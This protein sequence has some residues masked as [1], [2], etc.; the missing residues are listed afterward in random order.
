MSDFAQC[1]N[2]LTLVNKGIENVNSKLP[3]EKGP[4]G[5]LLHWFT[6]HQINKWIIFFLLVYVVLLVK[7]ITFKQLENSILFGAYSILVSIYILSRFLLAYFYDPTPIPNANYT[8]TVTF[9]TPAK[10]EEENISATLRAMMN[11][12]YPKSRFEIIAIND[13]STDAT[14]KEMKKVEKEAIASGVRLSVVNW[15][16]NRGKRHGMAEGILRSKSQIIV[17]VD[18]DSFVQPSTLRALVKYFQDRKVAAVAGHADVYN[19]DQNLLTKMQAVRY[20]VAFRAYKSAEALFGSV[21]CCSGC[22][23]AYRRKYVNR[24]LEPW[25]NQKFFGASC[26]YGDDRSLTNFL[27]RKYKA[28]YAPEAQSTTV[29]PDTWRGFMKQQLR[30]KKSWTRES[31]KAA[32]FMWKKNPIMSISFFLGVVLPLVAPV[33][34]VRALI[35]VPSHTGAFPIVYIMGLILMSA[36]YGI[37][38]LI[39]K[40][41]RLWIYGVLFA[42]FY[43]LV[44]VWQLPY[45]ILQ[46]RDSRWGTR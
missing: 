37:Y 33:I 12:N 13:G 36:L 16:K 20:Y 18:S 32:A 24:V 39:Y 14:L 25:L 27:I 6:S 4:F 2:E 7:V 45:A 44:L 46:L 15:K 43:S 8:P 30:W 38:Y 1:K 5:K 41:D 29:V 42:W 23:S 31:I 34:V 10:N 19:K 35:W 22:C 11:S 9:V 26:T 28:V 3:G 21:M 17:F 40:K